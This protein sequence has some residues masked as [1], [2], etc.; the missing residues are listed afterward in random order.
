MIFDGYLICSDCDGT[1]TDSQGHLSEENARA[2]RY[3]QK[4]GGRFTLAT[5]RF[6]NHLEQFQDSLQVNAP[7][8]ALNG[9]MLY[10]LER[11]REC[12]HWRMPRESCVQILRYI[13]ER[14]LAV[15][16]CWINCGLADG[17]PFRPAQDNLETFAAS[18]P[19]EWYKVVFVQKEEVTPHLQAELRSGFGE[20]F[21][22]ESSWPNGLEMQRMDSGKGLAI[23]TLKECYQGAV[24][25]VV[26][27]GDA[28]NDLTMMAVADIS[29]AV[30]NA[31]DLVKEAAD[32][33]T[34]S[35]D[36]HALAHIIQE[37]EAEIL[38]TGK[39]E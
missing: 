36:E 4:N 5:G 14:K 11:G 25:T 27:A 15:D 30:A 33:V 1:L 24:H 35:N 32:R 39:A 20:Q 29:Y 10:D 6:V 18:M 31:I 21:R 16:E 38:E 7:V 28:E 19:E 22:F 37:L 34:V 12:N 2:I 17:F 9:T 26:C 3:F 13:Q 23:Q 8:V